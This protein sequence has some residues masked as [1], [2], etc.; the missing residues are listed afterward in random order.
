MS[1]KVVTELLTVCNTDVPIKSVICEFD[2]LALDAP[3]LNVKVN[4]PDA[5]NT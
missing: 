3:L 1:P 5:V 2:A 4:P